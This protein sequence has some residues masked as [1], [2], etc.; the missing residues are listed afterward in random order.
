MRVLHLP[1]AIGG[2]A[3]NLSQGERFNGIESKVL[4]IGDNSFGFKCDEKKDWQKNKFTYPI[5]AL[6]FYKKEL[7][8]YDILHFNFGKTI[9]D[10][11]NRLINMIDLPFIKK[12]G[13]KIVVT[14]QGSDARLASYCINNY[15]VS[16]Y[17]HYPSK[18]LAR[19]F[20]KD[21][22]K[23]RRINKM[24]KYADLI[25]TTNPDLL[26]ILPKRAVF[27]PYTKIQIEDWDPRYSDYSKEKL[28][29]AHAPTNRLIKGTDKIIETINIM[30]N[31]GAPIELLLIENMTNEKAIENLKKS[32]LVIDQL[33]A[34]FYGGLAVESM[35][36]GKPV[37]A[38]IRESD[39]I[40]IPKEMKEQ[41][42]I[43]NA[44]DY[45]LM[46]VINDL[47]QNKNKLLEIA[48]KSRNYVE[49]WHDSKKNAKDVI[50]NYEK[51]LNQ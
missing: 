15:E 44:T 38:Y 8:N 29:I 24:D 13:V 32:D 51:I 39:L 10:Y 31:N 21:K 3:W 17:K 19:E 16:F 40:H 1:S 7:K 5:K 36:L 11:K 18:L 45:N 47:I 9:F 43:I 25:Y 33:Y 23:I 50:A 46:H 49:R 4:N 12:S 20:K 14:Y 27:R 30:I 35:A 41:M 2:N 37:I 6:K 48:V 42:P 34:G 22:E 26:N 28:I